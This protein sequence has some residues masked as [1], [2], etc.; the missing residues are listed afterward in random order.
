MV[1]PTDPEKIAE[2]IDYLIENKELA[3][4]M[5]ENGFRAVFERYNWDVN[6]KKLLNIYKKLEGD[7][8]V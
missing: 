3:Y 2:A 8:I 4:K 1:D 5:G 6:E 7:K